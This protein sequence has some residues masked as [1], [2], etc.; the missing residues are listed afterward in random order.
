MA[1]LPYV[2]N[3]MDMLM[4]EDESFTMQARGLG[5]V[6]LGALVRLWQGGEARGLH[7]NAGVLLPTGKVDATDDM[8]DCADCK[9]DYPTQIGSG[10]WDLAPGVTWVAEA[11]DWSWGANWLETLRLGTNSEGYAFGNRHELSAWGVRRWGRAL[12]ASVRLAGAAWGDI[13][14]SDLDFDPMMAP[15]QDPDAQAGR[16]IDVLLGL[17]FK[18]APGAGKHRLAA[19]FG[20]PIWQDLDGPQLATDWAAS[21]NWQFWF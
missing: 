7:L 17:G 18:P 13:D 10:T 12:S 9:V 16:R 14:G 2:A 11:G 6:Q 8:P 21:I 1:S 20:V 4:S 15:T 3:S 19:E 5:G